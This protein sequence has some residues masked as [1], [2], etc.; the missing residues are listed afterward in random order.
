MPLLTAC[1][2]PVPLLFLIIV[3]G[4]AVGRIRIGH[5]SLGIAGVLFIGILAGVGIRYLT[6][7]ACSDIIESGQSTMKMF[8][9]LGTALFV[10]VIGFETG[11]SVRSNAKGSLT[12]FVIGAVMS[13]SGA[14]LMRLIAA[15]DPSVSYHSLLGILCGALTSTPGL[16][17]VCELI[18]EGG[19]EAVWG[20]GC[21]YLPGVILTVLFAQRFLRARRGS[22]TRTAEGTAARGLCSELMLVSVAAAVGSL[23]GSI[24]IPVLHI[25]LGGTAGSLSVGLL[26]GALARGRSAAL[27]PHSPVLHTL[28]TLGLAL[29]FAGAGVTT[30]VGMTGFDPKSVL[31]GA[32]ITLTAVFCGFLL[33]RA[34]S[35]LCDL[36]TGFIVAGGMTS[37]PA[38]GVL[39]PVASEASVCHFS[40]AYFGAL[41]SL[42]VALQVLVRC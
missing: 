25:S 13:L 28:R 35:P 10:S 39:T 24:G 23:L 16:S 9:R 14:L 38:Y 30:G 27:R 3:I 41:L 32:L 19:E 37:S 2:S 12:A 8:S 6:S 34:A 21:S 29:F 36:P 40:F 18:G 7:G 1:L 26:L 31:Y 22:G 17:T 15:W 4:F 33:C 5:V 42:T 20:Y 11:L